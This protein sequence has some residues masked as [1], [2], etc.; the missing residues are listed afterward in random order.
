MLRRLALVVVIVVTA[1]LQNINAQELNCQMSVT[2]RQVEGTDK[3]VYNTLQTAL[4]DFINNRRWSSYSFTIEERIECTI[5]I[6]VTERVSTDEFKAT[7]NVVLRRP[8]FKSSYNTVLLNLVDRDFQFKYVELQPLDFQD[9]AFASELTAIIGY[10]AYVL[11]GLDFDSFSPNGGTAFFEKAQNLVNLGQGSAYSGWKAFEGTKNRFW[12]TENLTNSSYG[13]LREFMY[14]YHRLGLDL[15][16]EN[17]E[18]GRAAITESLK[19]LQQANRDKPG[20]YLFQLIMDAKRD[21]IINVYSGAPDN[22][23]VVAVNLLNELDPSNTAKYQK[24]LE[25]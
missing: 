12:L 1:T 14:Q 2:T 21:E 17:V 20:S 9:N 11:V 10:Y 13:K 7:L 6:N 23:K 24:I 16:S 8:V 4:Y 3:Q 5:M 15:M 19:L 22:E 25:K 18:G